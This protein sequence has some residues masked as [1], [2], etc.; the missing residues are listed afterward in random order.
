MVNQKRHPSTNS[1]KSASSFKSNNSNAS[2][3]NPYQKV[4][5][6][7]DKIKKKEN[8]G[9]KASGQFQEKVKTANN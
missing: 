8:A 4:A 3:T 9:G 6:K 7:G 5:V 1:E 2:S